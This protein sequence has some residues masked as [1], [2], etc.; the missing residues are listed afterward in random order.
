MFKRTKSVAILAAMILIPATS[1]LMAQLKLGYVNS[2]A[3]L[4]AY[5]PAVEAR[6]KL[7]AE[8]AKW[9]Q[10]LQ[11]M[12]EDFQAAQQELEQQS[13]LLSDAKKQEKVKAL[14][15]MAQRAQQYQVQKWGENGEMARREQELLQ[16]VIDKVNAVIKKVGDD[17]KFD[18]IF[19]AVAGNLLY[20][21]EAHDMTQTIIDALK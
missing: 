5:P 12:S 7:E 6:K 1:P 16:P 10:E 19:D 9:T 13:L 4:A 20:A 17:N 8:S 18:F 14:E 15:Q 2:Q 11:K 3:V 21:K